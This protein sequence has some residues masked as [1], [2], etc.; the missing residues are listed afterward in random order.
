MDQRLHS[1]VGGHRS[2]GAVESQGFPYLS[3]EKI[4]HDEPLFERYLSNLGL[5][6]TM[7]ER[8]WVENVSH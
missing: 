4:P 3:S 2:Q 8:R 6:E 5:M 7:E 1:G